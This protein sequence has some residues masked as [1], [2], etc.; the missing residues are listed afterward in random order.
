MSKEE[1]VSLYF[2]QG[3]SDKE[4]HASLEK[5]D[6]GWVVNF[7]YGRRGSASN[8][9]TKT[10]EPVD[11]GVAKSVYDKLV[12]SKVAKGYVPDESGKVF[13]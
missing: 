6:K 8:T 13:Q 10:E 3:S 9:G 1:S 7:K 4:Y 2:S 5:K 12:V 11:Y